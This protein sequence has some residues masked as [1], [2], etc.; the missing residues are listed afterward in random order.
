MLVSRYDRAMAAAI[1]GPALERLPE[2]LADSH[3]H[4]FSLDNMAR[5][6]KALAA[7]DPRAVVA[8]IRGLPDS[9]RRVPKKTNTWNAASPEAQLRLAAAEMLGLP[10][11]ERRS[12]AIGGND[13]PWPFRRAFLIEKWSSRPRK[14][15]AMVASF[16]SRCPH[17]GAPRA[18]LPRCRRVSPGPEIR[19]EIDPGSR[20]GRRSPGRR[21]RRSSPGSSSRR[22]PRCSSRAWPTP[23]VRVPRGRGRRRTDH[24][25]PGIRPS[26]ASGRGRPVRRR[27]GTAWS[28]RRSPSARR[29][30]STRTSARWPS[31]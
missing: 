15:V 12:K 7:Y 21:R 18:G 10:F 20:P 28:I 17:A 31:P 22:P 11:D 8:L 3:R 6:I 9:A 16:A 25:D 1:I 26:R 27:V 4:S 23:R 30:T 5:A 24:Q 13:Q 14:G 29:P 2:L 19:G